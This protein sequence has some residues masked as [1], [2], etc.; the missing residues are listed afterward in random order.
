MNG[1]ET[2]VQ[3]LVDSGVDVCFAN[4]GTSEMHFVGA[5]DSNPA[6]RCV[7]CLFEGVVSAAADGY[8]RMAGRPAATL[9]HLGPGLANAGANLHNAMRAGTPM[10]NIVGDHATYHLHLDAPLTSDI[11]GLARTWS[12]WVHTARNARAVA[13]DA[14]EAVRRAR[15]G[16][17]AT[18]ILPADTAWTTGQEPAKAMA[19]SPLPVPPD[20]R[21]KAAA[22]LL[23]NG[24]RTLLLVG[25]K[26][27]ADTGALDNADRIAHASG[28]D[29][30]APT[31]NARVER[32]AGRV[33]IARLPYPV[34]DALARTAGI[35]Q[36]I[37]VDAQPPVAFFA[38]PGKPGS[39]L[40]VGCEVFTLAHRREDAGAALAALA[41]EL[42][43]EG[44]A[45]RHAARSAPQA[46]S[47]GALTPEAIGQALANRLPEN[48][49]VCDE[50]I[51]TGG[52]AVRATGAAAPHSWLQLTGGAIGIG[53]PL[54]IGAAVACPGRK[55]VVLQADGSGM[56][57]NQALWTHAREKLDIVSIVLS[58]RS[59]AILRHELRNVGVLNPGPKALDMT[60]L[61]NPAIDWPL[62]ARGMGVPGE[63]AATGA[64]FDALLA[65]AFSRP[66][67]SL[68]EAD[69]TATV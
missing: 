69:L 3:T 14:A 21:I 17:I 68:I 41:T 66:G 22:R 39:L 26:A 4:P 58:N 23:R 34:D 48:A 10:V 59:Y 13:G 45:P 35:E 8:A 18:L 24:K 2:L 63:R 44:I 49:I 27:L 54:A 62:L 30:L 7:L 57:T 32:G 51:T 52:P 40:P 6:I 42:G 16:G 64:E 61:A 12:S 36:C 1:A 5:L 31:S 38:Y 56:Y 53:L 47:S 33:N 11:E 43:G 46:V 67:P 55:V 28:A 29:L 65:E 50:A 20:A 60:S 25:G 19:P 15:E 37:C 9:L